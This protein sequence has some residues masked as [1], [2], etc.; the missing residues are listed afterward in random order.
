[1]SVF[2]LL[3]PIHFRRRGDAIRL[4]RGHRPALEPTGRGHRPGIGARPGVSWRR[5]LRYDHA[6]IL[7]A[8]STGG[9][10]RLSPTGGGLYG[11]AVEFVN[12]IPLFG[13]QIDQIQI[14][15]DSLYVGIGTRTNDG[16]D[17][18][19]YNGTIA[20]IDDLTKSNYSANGANNLALA[21][22]LTDTIPAS[23]TS[24][25]RASA[26]PTASASTPAATSPSPTT[27]AMLRFSPPT[28]STPTSTP[29]IAEPFPH[30]TRATS[31]PW[32]C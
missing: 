7:R 12:N 17:E 11:N 29:A 5:P 31:P 28:F 18:T 1:M 30:L 3:E 21:N 27:V 2:R 24:S 13:H 19:V 25:P 22:V 10:V 26:T 8:I 6:N 32:P 4:R 15:G 20:R 16:S 23:S 14:S 9:L